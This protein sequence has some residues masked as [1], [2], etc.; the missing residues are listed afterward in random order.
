MIVPYPSSTSSALSCA[1]Y[2][3]VRVAGRSSRFRSSRVSSVSTLLGRLSSA[4]RCSAYGTFAV[5]TLAHSA[6]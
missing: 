1:L 6:L 3:W 2:D 4:A 5:S